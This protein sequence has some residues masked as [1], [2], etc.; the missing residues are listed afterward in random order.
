MRILDLT[1]LND[2]AVELA[3]QEKARGIIEKYLRDI[4][5]FYEWLG[6]DKAVTR[7]RVTAYKEYLEETRATST[8]KSKMIALN[9][10]FAYRGWDECRVSS[11]IKMEETSDLKNEKELT[12]WEYYKL[13]NTAR[14]NGDDRLALIIETIGSCGLRVSELQMITVESVRSGVAKWTRN[15]KT[16]E[17]KLGKNLRKK[18]KAFCEKNGI[19]EGSVFQS[20]YGNPL[21]RVYISRKMKILSEKAEVDEEKV[22]LENLRQFENLAK[23]IQINILCFPIFENADKYYRRIAFCNPEPGEYIFDKFELLETINEDE[24]KQ[25]EYEACQKTLQDYKS[26]IR[27]AEKRGRETLLKQLVEKK[28]S[29]GKSLEVIADELEEEVA[30]IQKIV[31][32]IQSEE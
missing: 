8:A 17:V 3:K 25:M 9:V 22:F 4:S 26:H 11:I 14:N 7:G 29:K 28:L 31:E 18:L 27:S 20:Q 1:T 23:C 19:R 30:T 32:E 10:Y 24:I 6:E 21:N 5:Y 13:I 12:L 15:K 2:Y 16:R